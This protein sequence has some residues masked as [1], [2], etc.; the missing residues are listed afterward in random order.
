MTLQELLQEVRNDPEY[1]H[2]SLLIKNEGG[3]PVR[4]SEMFE[5]IFQAKMG[6]AGLSDEE[7]ERLEIEKNLYFGTLTGL[8]RSQKSQ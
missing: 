1:R 3:D 7:Q 6:Q 4:F 8:V 5:S 2:L